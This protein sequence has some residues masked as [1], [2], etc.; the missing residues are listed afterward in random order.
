MS[1]PATGVPQVPPTLEQQ[2]DAAVAEA[3]QIVAGFS[4]AVG[5]AIQMGAAVEPVISGIVHMFIGLFHH[6]VKKQQGT[7]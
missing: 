2:I 6:S 4:P 5:Q 7:A 3:S 1:A